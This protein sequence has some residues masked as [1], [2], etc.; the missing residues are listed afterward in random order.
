[1]LHSEDQ[2]PCIPAEVSTF[3][4]IDTT[5]KDVV[6]EEVQEEALEAARRDPPFFPE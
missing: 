5:K 6:V 3:Q 1:M 2:P 4:T